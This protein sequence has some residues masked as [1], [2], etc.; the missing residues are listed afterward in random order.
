M[1][2]QRY[3]VAVVGAGMGGLA[4]A[5]L[6][7]RTGRSVA[8]LERASRPGGASQAF[9]PEGYRFD[10]G[11][12]L[13]VGFGPGGSLARLCES[14]GIGL[15]V[16]ECEPALQVALPKHRIG[17]YAAPE[18]WWRE[19]RREFPQEE[20]GW[21][22]L[23]SE[24][25]GLVRERERI[26]H[27]L[28]SLPP[29]GWGERFKVWRVCTL[30]SLSAVP[31]QAGVVLGQAL[32]APFR[33]TMVRHGLGMES[34]RVL[35][36]CLW[37]LLLRTADRCSTLEAAVALEQVR[38]GVVAIPGGV[39][40]LVEALTDQFQRH[41]GKLLLETEVTRCL[42]EHGRVVG[43]VTAAGET[44][45][46]RWVVADVPPSVLAERLLPSER[47]WFQRRR[48]I[49]G[50]WH[51]ARIAQVLTLA[52]RESLI[53]SELGGHCFIVRD[54]H[55]PARD[56][57]LVFIRTAPAWDA[58]QGPAGIRC[59]TVGQ[60][61]ALRTPEDVSVEADLLEALEQIVPGAGQGI[62]FRHLHPS[63]SLAAMWGRPS[64]AARYERD[65]REWLGY[66]GMS[67]RTGWPGLL[68]VGE[69]TYPGR[70]I[71]NVVEGAMQAVDMI[72]KGT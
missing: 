42:L 46:A 4:A 38:R 40:V 37:Y 59:L 44:I 33:A 12:T 55:R 34:Q 5:C 29:E 72:T 63:A 54:P 65:S 17:L 51:P 23:W 14:L 36:A 15:D 66:R 7:A 30:G 64:A 57:N 20:T 31:P 1:S 61:A 45:R 32:A 67:H 3:D 22:A 10:I 11:A 21:R 47:G 68:A 53:P 56:E 50:P 60:F 28:P 24:V 69:W 13:L 70:L 2:E 58:G 16:K 19:V 62:V 41:G 26:R 8:L 6:L 49:D 52:V 25:D 39:T 43:V 9:T 18:S 35:D 71:S 48:A 27:E